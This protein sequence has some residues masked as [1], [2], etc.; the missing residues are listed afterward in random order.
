MKGFDPRRY[1]PSGDYDSVSRRGDED[2]TVAFLVTRSRVGAAAAQDVTQEGFK[3]G[4]GRFRAGRWRSK[5]RSSEPGAAWSSMPQNEHTWEFSIRYAAR[6][7]DPG[8]DDD[9]R[10]RCHLWSGG[11]EGICT[12]GFLRARENRG[13]GMTCG[14]GRTAAMAWDDD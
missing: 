13:C 11:G 4:L 8:H 1:E 10:C 2:E 6:L 5:E 7:P 14:A 9:Q 3:V 12:P